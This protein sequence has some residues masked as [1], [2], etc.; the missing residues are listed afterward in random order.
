MPFPIEIRHAALD[1]LVDRPLQPF[2]QCDHRPR[3]GLRLS[4]S[5]KQL[6]EC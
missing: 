3:T 5:A 6:A 4:V 1:A 2:A